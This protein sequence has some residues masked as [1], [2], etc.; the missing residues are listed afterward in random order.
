MTEQEIKDKVT[1]Y[2]SYADIDWDDIENYGKIEFELYNGNIIFEGNITHYNDKTK[3]GCGCCYGTFDVEGDI[4]V[5]EEDEPCVLH[6]E[7]KDF[8]YEF[9]TDY[10]SY[11]G[12]RESDFY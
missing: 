1:D 6:Y 5:C 10:Y 9:I 4:T 3:P 11:Y 2:I 8:E 7:E 12:V